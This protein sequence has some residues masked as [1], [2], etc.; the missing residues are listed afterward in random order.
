[1]VRF[2][3]TVELGGKT[4]TGLTVPEDVVAQL[5]PGRRHR[6]CVTI[7]GYTYRSSVAFHQGAFKIPLSAEHREAAGVA[8]GDE[9]E[10][11]L[12]L[13]DQPRTVD[14]PPELAA[15]LDD[16]TRAAFDAL[17]FTNQQRIVLSVTGAKTE[18]TRERRI[19]KAVAELREK[20]G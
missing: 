18:A 7:G 4:A 16:R 6:V 2:A 15:A 13:D 11:E 20:A 17:S 8:A 19:E 3:T 1:M 10:V 9:V 5:G 14:V 12:A